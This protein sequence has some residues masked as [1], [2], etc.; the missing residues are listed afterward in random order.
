MKIFSRNKR[1]IMTQLV[2]ALILGSIMAQSNNLK[3]SE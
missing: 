1:P 2:M 3:S